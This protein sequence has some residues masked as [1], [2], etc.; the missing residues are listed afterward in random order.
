LQEFS[1]GN[2][3]KELLL[4][5]FFNNAQNQKESH[6]QIIRKISQ[7][8]FTKHLNSSEKHATEWAKKS[9]YQIIKNRIKS[10][11]SL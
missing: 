2:I 7:H 11:P 10:Y 3:K 4:Q 1:G 9:H 6:Y 5:R 8:T